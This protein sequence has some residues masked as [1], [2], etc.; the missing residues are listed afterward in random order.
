MAEL[1]GQTPG[2][3]LILPETPFFV[4]KWGG[5]VVDRC[6]KYRIKNVLFRMS[7]FQNNHLI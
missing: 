5:V 4:L 6:I 1:L 3:A 7:I 2:S